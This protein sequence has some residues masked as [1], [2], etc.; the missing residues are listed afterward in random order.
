MAPRKSTTAA[1]ASPDPWRLGDD[2]SYYTIKSIAKESDLASMVSYGAVVEGQG[3]VSGK[4][5]VPSPGE[6]RM[7]VFA[8]FF[9]ARLCFLC[10]ILPDVPDVLQL[11]EAKQTQLSP[12]TLTRIVV[13]D[14]MCRIAGF[15]PTTELFGAI[16]GASILSKTAQTPA[17]PQKIVFGSVN[18]IVRSERSDV[19]PV[20]TSVLK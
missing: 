7:L 16:F 18:F 10:D 2:L 15:T 12:S 11:Y 3:F 4:A 19:W 20:P 14:W 17:G 1:T 5:L 6:G 8:T 9:D 13:F